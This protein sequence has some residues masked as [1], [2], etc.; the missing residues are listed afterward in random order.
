MLSKLYF[1]HAPSWEE[2]KILKGVLRRNR[3]CSSDSV[4]S[5]NKR[6]LRAAEHS[7]DS[8]RASVWSSLVAGTTRAL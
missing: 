4:L 5:P 2:R 6:V 8:P 3:G 1:S 7:V